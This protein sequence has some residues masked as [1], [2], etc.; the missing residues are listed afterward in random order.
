MGLKIMFA[1]AIILFALG[2]IASILSIKLK[3]NG[4]KKYVGILL[5]VLIILFVILFPILMAIGF[6]LNDKP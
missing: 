5:P 4:T 2:I 6:M 1:V 3:E